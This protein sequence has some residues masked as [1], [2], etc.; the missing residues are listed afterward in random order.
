LTWRV[1]D[2]GAAAAEENMATDKKLLET[3]SEGDAPI[4]RFYS[5]KGTCATYGYFNNPEEHLNLENVAKHGL[6]LARRPTGG[7]IIFHTHDFTF[8]AIVPS[9]HPRFS[10]NTLENYAFINEAVIDALAP[11]AAPARLFHRGLPEKD[12]LSRQFCMAKPTQYDVMIDGKKVGGAAQRRTKNGFLHQGTI[13]LA[14]PPLPFLR[15][16]LKNNEV[17]IDAMLANSYCLLTDQQKNLQQVKK[18]LQARLT[19]SLV[20]R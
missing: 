6:D 16:V 10:T 9:S 7:G 15:D 4:L 14:I 20:R 5:W 2:S 11:L 1:L 19:E 8:S 18:E 17:I 12:S 13:S 3:I